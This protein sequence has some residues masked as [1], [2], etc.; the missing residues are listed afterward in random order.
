[1]IGWTCFEVKADPVDKNFGSIGNAISVVVVKGGESWR[2]QYDQRH[3]LRVRGFVGGQRGLGDHDD[4]TRT[5]HFG[6]VLEFVCFSVPI[7]IPTANNPA[8]IRR[9]VERTI[10]INTY[11]DDSIG[12]RGDARRIV[13]IGWTREQGCGKTGGDLDAG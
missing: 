12:G 7:Q 2:V 8:A 5:V 9:F 4:S 3:L 1:M 13:D 11:E 6:K 10:F